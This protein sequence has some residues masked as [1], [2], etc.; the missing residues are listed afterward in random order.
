MGKRNSSLSTPVQSQHVRQKK[1]KTDTMALCFDKPQQIPNL[2]LSQASTF[3]HSTQDVVS[4]NSNAMLTRG[5]Y[6]VV[7]KATR[8]GMGPSG[9]RPSVGGEIFRTRL[10]RPWGQ[11]SLLYT[12]YRVSCPGVKQLRHD[13]DHPPLPAPNLKWEAILLLP[14][15]AFISCLLGEIYDG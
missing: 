5:R 9:D 6:N 13:V 11:T 1:K 2:E 3:K 8:Y 10:D 4:L 12:G 7:D 15:W 14:P